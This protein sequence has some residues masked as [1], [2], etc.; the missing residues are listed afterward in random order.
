[1]TPKDPLA[2]CSIQHISAFQEALRGYKRHVQRERVRKRER[3]WKDNTGKI[4]EASQELQ[5]FCPIRCPRSVPFYGNAG[6]PAPS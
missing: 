3:V 1:M 4:P 6:K 5:E 2:L